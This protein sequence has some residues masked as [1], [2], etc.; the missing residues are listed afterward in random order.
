MPVYIFMYVYMYI[1][2]TYMFVQQVSPIV[3][4]IIYRDVKYKQSHATIWQLYTS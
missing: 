1:Y 3:F 4:Y 2:T